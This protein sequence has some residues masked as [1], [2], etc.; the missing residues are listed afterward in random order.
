MTNVETKVRKFYQTI[1]DEPGIEFI[2]GGKIEFQGSQIEECHG[3]HD[4]G[5]GCDIT[6]TSVEIVIAGSGIDIL[7][8]LSKKQIE[9]IIGKIEVEDL[10]YV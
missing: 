3:F 7:S 5:G 6:L 2:A 4:V 9:K 8:Q 10:N 1:I